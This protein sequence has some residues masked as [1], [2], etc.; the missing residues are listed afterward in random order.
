M[1]RR[2]TAHPSESF[3]PQPLVLLSL[4]NVS[5]RTAALLAPRSGLH[6][7]RPVANL[8]N[9]G[10]RFI[11]GAGERPCPYRQEQFITALPLESTTALS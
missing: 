7:D 3:G 8:E 2:N 9:R 1:T 5:G 6:L 10:M 4:A 11:V